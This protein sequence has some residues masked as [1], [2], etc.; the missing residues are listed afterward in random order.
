MEN[1]NAAMQAGT[2]E[3][4]QMWMNWMMLVFASSIL[5]VRHHKP[6]R[7]SLAALFAT[8]VAGFI[9]WKTT[10]NIHLLGIAHLVFWLPLAVYF[11]R[12]EF[13]SVNRRK[14]ANSKIYYGWLT[15]LLATI[16]VSLVFDV[17]DIYLVLTG[18]K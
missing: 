3:L 5:F 18:A 16:L 1:L 4:V 17:R 13:S 7:W 6:A 8:I 11:W 9:I 14:R 10:Q 15:L 12:V 2:S